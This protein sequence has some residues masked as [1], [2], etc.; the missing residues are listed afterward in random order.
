MPITPD[1]V[2]EGGVAYTRTFTTQARDFLMD[3]KYDQERLDGRRK[4][5]GEDIS[6]VKT[7]KP[8]LPPRSPSAEL[9]TEADQ[10]ETAFRAMNRRMEEKGWEID[11]DL[12]ER[13]GR[14]QTFVIPSPARLA[15]PKNWVHKA[16]PTTRPRAYLARETEAAE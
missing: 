5:V 3:E 13:E 1:T 2:T 10:L 14:R 16:V 7:V 12:V 9:L 4:A 8:P 15:D 6:I 11:S